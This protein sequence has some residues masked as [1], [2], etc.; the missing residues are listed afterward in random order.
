M[1]LPGTILLCVLCAPLPWGQTGFNVNA[2]DRSAD[3]CVDFCQYACGTWM[4]NNPI[5]PD[6]AI[7]GRFTGLEERNRETLRDILEKAPANDPKRV[8]VTRKIGDFDSA[9][10]AG[11]PRLV[12]ETARGAGSRFT[13]G[14]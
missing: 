9:W 14:I 11:V 3:P 12:T 5:P 2:L 13:A 8:A 4:K 6:R 1:R 7:W 10:R